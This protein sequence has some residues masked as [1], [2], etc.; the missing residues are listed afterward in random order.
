MGKAAENTWFSAGPEEEGTQLSVPS[1]F[2][3]NLLTNPAPTPCLSMVKNVTNA[4]SLPYGIGKKHFHIVQDIKEPSGSECQIMI[5]WVELLRV[6]ENQ[7]L[8]SW[9]NEWLRGWLVLV[10]KK[11]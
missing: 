9:G 2:L 11:G 10:K 4:E 3:S 8:K 1:L 7:E 5:L 6:M